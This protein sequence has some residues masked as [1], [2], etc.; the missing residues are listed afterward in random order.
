MEYE[1][2]LVNHLIDILLIMSC[3]MLILFAL[4]RWR[5]IVVRPKFVVVSLLIFGTVIFNSVLRII[6]DIRSVSP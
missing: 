4:A 1:Q 2:I 3:I 5:H 6:N